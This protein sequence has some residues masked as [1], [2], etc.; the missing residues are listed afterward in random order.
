[1]PGSHRIAYAVVPGDDP[2]VVLAEDD[3]ILTRAVALEVVASTAPAEL[4]DRVGRIREALLEDEWL[5][6]C[7]LYTSPSPRD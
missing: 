1:M 4:G 2:I 3:E 6:A 5:E 7:L